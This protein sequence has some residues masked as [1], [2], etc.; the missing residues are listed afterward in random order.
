MATRVV[1]VPGSM[2]LGSPAADVE[3]V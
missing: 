3:V 2:A 1:G